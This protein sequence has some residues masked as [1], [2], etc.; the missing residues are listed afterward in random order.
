MLYDCEIIYTPP[1]QLYNSGTCHKRWRTSLGTRLLLPQPPVR[2]H[3]LKC[4]S[5]TTTNCIVCRAAGGRCPP[6]RHESSP[7]WR[8]LPPTS[9]IEVN[10][11]VIYNLLSVN[12]AWSRMVTCSS[13]AIRWPVLTYFYTFILKCMYLYPL[14]EEMYI[15]V[16]KH[17]CSSFDSCH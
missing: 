4:I 9:H 12:H 8:T 10:L 3:Q 13:R 15:N 6:L 2:R 16:L 1:L 7:W 11:T 17:L 5:G 14:T